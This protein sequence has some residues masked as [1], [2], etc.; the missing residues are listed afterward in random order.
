MTTP[1]PS[2][3]LGRS[4]LRVGQLCLG[5]MTFSDESTSREIYSAFREAG[6]I[7]IDTA[8]IYTGGESERIVGQLVKAERDAIVVATKF[9]LPTDR[10]DLNSG[11]SHRKSLRRS[12]EESLARL[13]TDY[14]DL[15]WTHAWDQ[16]TPA[17]ETLRG[18]DDLVRAGKV[19]AIGVSNTPAWVVAGSTAI[20]EL[21]G[22]TSFCA[23]QVAYSLLERS[24]ERE[25]LPMA[26]GL[27]LSPLAWSPLARGRLSGRPGTHP[28]LEV[29]TDIAAKLD[30][31]PAQVALAWIRYH[32]VM[33]ILGASSAAQ[34]RDNLGAMTVH[35][36]DEHLSALDDAT[37]IDLGYPHNFLRDR[38]PRK[39]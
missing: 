26:R 8:N 6:G 4:G 16:Y 22:W 7:F 31:T 25:L 39:S 18:L 17:E 5:T 11:G 2:T 34:V 28:V 27:G 19:L 13:H 23:L 38:S 32:G 3:V 10:D 36:A 15:L 9:T 35:L 14:I 1:E 21:R 30:R 20:A 12:V 37:R 33:P 29:L 24:A